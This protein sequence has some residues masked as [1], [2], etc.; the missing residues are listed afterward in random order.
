MGYARSN[1]IRGE[2]VVHT[3]SLHWYMFLGPV[4]WLMAGG[5]AVL[6][7]VGLTEQG[8]FLVFGG[9]ILAAVNA[10]RLLGR[11]VRYVSPEFV[12]T[13]LRVIAKSGFLSRT[14]V[15]Q[16]L[17]KID[18]VA[19][20]QGIMGRMLGFGSVGVSTGG[21]TQVFPW[22]TD[23]LQLRRVVQECQSESYR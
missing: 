14:T 22:I 17:P 18:A 16:M 5:V 10:I 20:D 11:F 23:P 1:L 3:A 8:P 12:V 2:Q 19:V 21:S 6:V 15:E 7:G 13:N 9:I 4:V